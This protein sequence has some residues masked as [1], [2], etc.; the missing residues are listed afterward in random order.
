M[1]TDFSIQATNHTVEVRSPT[2]VEDVMEVHAITKPSGVTFVRAVPYKTW[3]AKGAG[4]A[5]GVIAQHIEHIMAVRP[6]VVSGAAIQTV[7]QSGLLANAV[8]FVVEYQSADDSQPG[9][10]H[11]TVVIPVQ[12]LH[13]D[14]TFDRFFDPVVKRLADQAGL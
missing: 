10:F 1:A 14:D 2:L 4:P 11:D 6:H 7:D 13:D 5:L 8:E 9:P 12:A 3:Q